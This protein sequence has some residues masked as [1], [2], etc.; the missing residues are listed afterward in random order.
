MQL[1]LAPAGPNLPEILLTNEHVDKLGQSP[2]ALRRATHRAA[3]R[4]DDQI[5]GHRL[6]DRAML[7]DA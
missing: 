7:V 2:A 1:P 4:L 6:L 5:A 3:I